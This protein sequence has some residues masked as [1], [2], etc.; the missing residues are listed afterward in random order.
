M[1]F[2]ISVPNIY[3]ITWVGITSLPNFG[4]ILYEV[5]KLSSEFNECFV[6]FTKKMK[7][8]E[9]TDFKVKE[10]LFLIFYLIYMIFFYIYSYIA[11]KMFIYMDLI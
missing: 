10:F 8:I 9:C 3:P 5:D 7:N 6:D 1:N 4:S 11:F 2:F